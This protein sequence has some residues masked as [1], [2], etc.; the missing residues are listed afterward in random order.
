MST[1]AQVDLDWAEV[2]ASNIPQLATSSNMTRLTR[3]EKVL[4]LGKI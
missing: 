2:D 3:G 4:K 1:G